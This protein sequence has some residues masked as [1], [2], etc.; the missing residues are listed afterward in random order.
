MLAINN[1]SISSIVFEICKEGDTIGMII[2]VMA[3]MI[4]IYDLSVSNSDDSMFTKV[5][6]HFR[7]QKLLKIKLLES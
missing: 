1:F 2:I 7:L 5:H 6:F 4:V 3:T